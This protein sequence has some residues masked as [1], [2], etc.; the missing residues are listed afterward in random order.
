[1]QATLEPGVRRLVEADPAAETQGAPAAAAPEQGEEPTTDAQAA[2]VLIFDDVSGRFDAGDDTTP[3]ASTGGAILDL[4]A[5][6][7]EAPEGSGPA[8]TTQPEAADASDGEAGDNR[9]EAA[10]LTMEHGSLINWHDTFT[11]PAAVEHGHGT[12]AGAPVP[13]FVIYTAEAAAS[14]ADTRSDGSVPRVLPGLLEWASPRHA[15]LTTGLGDT[16]D[17]KHNAQRG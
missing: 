16:R 15:P 7:T 12:A 1:M 6:S 17:R 8:G 3:P 10:S 5:F 9:R 4:A 13:A 2:A 14:L 11:A